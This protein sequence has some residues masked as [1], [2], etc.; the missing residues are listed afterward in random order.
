M[1]KLATIRQ[2]SEIK[3]IP[4]ADLLELAII[5]GWQ[6]VI[7][8]GE[9]KV[10]DL[11]VYCEIDSFLPIIPEYEFLRKNCYRKLSDG[12]E[13]FLIKTVKLRGQLSQ[14]LVL[15]LVNKRWEL[16]QDVTEALGITLYDPLVGRENIDTDISGKFPYFI[17]KTYEERLQNLSAK[18][19][20]LKQRRYTVTE[21]LDGTSFTCY[22][23]NEKFGVCSRNWEI[24]AENSMYWKIA[25]QY[26]LAQTLPE[27][28]AIQGEVIGPGIQG[29]KY[30]LK[31]TDLYVFNV[32]DIKQ[33]Q[34]LTQQNAQYTA[35]KLGI[36]FV[37]VIEQSTLL[38][39][40]VNEVLQLA[41]GKSCL[42][43][44]AE[45]EGLVFVS[46]I[47]PRIS[48]KVISNSFLLKDK[49]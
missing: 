13:G 8:K 40:T 4:N 2:I 29:N 36:K 18:F 32:Y 35:T 39:N 30:E 43:K 33:Q 3:Q 47:D 20:Q 14:G 6:A 44:H 22:K 28:L 11:V 48:F 23:W 37:P 17:P 10:G 25:K 19:E 49:N 46:D 34:Y 24:E 7:K 38:P 5:D 45:R 1:R 9:F 15:P 26:N 27:G 21:K 12:S 41:I 16:N 42:N 31:D